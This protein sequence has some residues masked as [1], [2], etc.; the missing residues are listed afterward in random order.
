MAVHTALEQEWV[1][2]DSNGKKKILCK[3]QTKKSQKFSTDSSLRGNGDTLT[4]NL[5]DIN[6]KESGIVPLRRW[7][8]N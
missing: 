4:W 1:I 6:T 7:P 2:N 5:C 3:N 8:K